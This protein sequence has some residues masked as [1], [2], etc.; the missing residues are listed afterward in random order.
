MLEAPKPPQTRRG[1]LPVHYRLYHSIDRVG[2]ERAS[3]R[4]HGEAPAQGQP[5]DRPLTGQRRLYTVDLSGTCPR[6]TCPDHTIRQTTCK[7]IWATEYTIKRE[8]APDGA[9]TVTK[10]VRVTYKSASLLK[11]VET[12]FVV[13]PSAF[14]TSKFERWYDA[15]YGKMMGEYN[16]LF[17]HSRGTPGGVPAATLDRGG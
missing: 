1:K 8:T 15:E 16:R 3:H 9:T 10:T 6:C 5:V 7:H 11:A 12:S 2:T 14:T 17:V 4:H 13:D